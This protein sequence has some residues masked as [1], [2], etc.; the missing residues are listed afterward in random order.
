MN[1]NEMRY[2]KN[3]P[4]RAFGIGIASL[5]TVTGVL[6]SFVKAM[7][8]RD[9]KSI[10]LFFLA[11]SLDVFIIKICTEKLYYNQEV[12]KFKKNVYR[13]EDISY[14]LKTRMLRRGN[15]NTRNYGNNYQILIIYVKKN[16]KNKKITSISE[17]CGNYD[18]LKNIIFRKIPEK[19]I[20]K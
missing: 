2:I 3:Y 11:Y 17:M 7:Q 16:G 18:D 12:I 15:F 9:I 19:I 4:R 8:I 14:E 20:L 10:I 6:A 5:W 1:V 13:Y